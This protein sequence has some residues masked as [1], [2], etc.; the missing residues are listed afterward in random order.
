MSIQTAPMRFQ[1]RMTENSTAP[2]NH[3]IP[4]TCKAPRMVKPQVDSRSSVLDC[5]AWI[6]RQRASRDMALGVEIRDRFRADYDQRPQCERKDS[7]ESSAPTMY[8]K[9]R[10]QRQCE[11]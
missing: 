9:V 4:S 7:A 10:E 5:V 1:V 2:P 11:K 3:A 6:Q 8:G